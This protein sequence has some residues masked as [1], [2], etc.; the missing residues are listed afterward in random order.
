MKE[1]LKKTSALYLRN[2]IFGVEDSLVSTGGLLS[3]VAAAG[4]E[5]QEIFLTGMILIFVEAFSMGS[6][7]YLSESFSQDFT[8]EKTKF[9][10]RSFLA[11]TIMFFS[12]FSAGFIPLAPYMIL[13]VPQAFAVSIIFSLS[14]LFVLGAASAK[15]M[16]LK[17]LNH[18]LRMFIIGGLAIL[19]GCL[20]GKFIQTPFL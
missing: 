14:A 9:R 12:Y 19:I 15:F 8:K 20:V 17:V 18:G 16:Q 4:L 1:D 6:G 5:R 3:G 11:S 10:S 13:P 7:S 2:F